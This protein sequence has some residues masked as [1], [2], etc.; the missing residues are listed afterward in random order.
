MNMIDS[1]EGETQPEAIG[2]KLDIPRSFLAR[3]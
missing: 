3:S 1:V 2:E